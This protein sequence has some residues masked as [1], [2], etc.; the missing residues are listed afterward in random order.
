MRWTVLVR[1]KEWARGQGVSYRIALNWLPA[2]TL[3]VPARQVPAGTVVVGPRTRPVSATVAYCRVWSAERR[4]GL[5]RQARR[6]AQECG[7]RG[8]ALDSTVTERADAAMTAAQA[9]Q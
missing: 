3:P 7:E 2:G 4:D 6:V 5:E 1:L 8:S 9:A